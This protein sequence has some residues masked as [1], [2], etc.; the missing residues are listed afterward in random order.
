MASSVHV[1]AFLLLV[2]D[3]AGV[4]MPCTSLKAGLVLLKS[5]GGGVGRVPGGERGVEVFK[6]SESGRWAWLGISGLCEA[7]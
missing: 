2:G 6:G 7:P 4:E 1:C 5:S 3:G